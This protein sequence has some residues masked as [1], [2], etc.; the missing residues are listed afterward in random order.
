MQ[1]LQLFDLAFRQNEWLAQRQSV[2]AS[3]IANANTPGYKAREIQGFDDEMAKAT[4][5]VT[6][7]AGHIAPGNNGTVSANESNSQDADVFVSGND[8]TLEQ[9]FLKSGEVMRG[10]SMNTQILKSFSRMLMSVT[11]G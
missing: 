1:P 10:Y 9:E 2:I 3:N 4:A 7:N 5:M 6:T 11:K 8:V